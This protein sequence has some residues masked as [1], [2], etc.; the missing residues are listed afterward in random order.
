VKSHKNADIK[1]DEEL[2]NNKRGKKCI[3]RSRIGERGRMESKT[4]KED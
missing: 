3:K 1:K 2:I 4:E